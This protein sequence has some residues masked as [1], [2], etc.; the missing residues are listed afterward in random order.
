MWLMTH[1]V[2]EIIGLTSSFEQKTA[3]AND[4]TPAA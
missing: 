1:M 4:V 2:D 3:L